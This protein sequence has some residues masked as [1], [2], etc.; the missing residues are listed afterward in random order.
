MR[1]P[2]IYFDFETTPMLVETYSFYDSQVIR[3]REHIKIMSVSW[4]WEGEDDIYHLALPDFK[5]HKAGLQN[6]NDYKLVKAFS[7]ILMKAD[8]AYAHNGNGF[9]FKVWRTRLLKHGLDPMHNLKEY[10]TKKWAKKFY[11]ANN[12]QDN[13]SDE[14]GTQRKLEHSKNMHYRCYELNDPKAWSENKKYNNWDVKGLKEN[15]H[16]IAPHVPTLST[17]GLIVCKNPLCESSNLKRDKYWQVMK[18]W[19]IQFVCKDCGKYT[20]AGDTY[21][22]KPLIRY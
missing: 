16:K 17:T 21:P 20:T 7:E 4:S 3:I 14:L 22:E 11:F 18:G 1:K 9:D 15:A 6:V 2:T 19:K 12:K 10:D 8:S 5:G 13:I